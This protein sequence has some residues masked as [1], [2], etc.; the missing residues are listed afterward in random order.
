[1]ASAEVAWVVVGNHGTDLGLAVVEGEH[2]LSDEV[3]GVWAEE[4]I[5][6][7]VVAKGSPATAGL[8]PA[9]PHLRDTTKII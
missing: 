4:R 1:V 7:D 5:C 2:S 6:S 3:R 9:T 8:S